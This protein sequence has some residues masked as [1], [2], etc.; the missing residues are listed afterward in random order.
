MSRPSVVVAA[1]AALALP[2]ARPASAQGDFVHGR[3]APPSSASAAV[4]EHAMHGH[5]D[6]L[7]RLHLGMTPVPTRREKARRV[8]QD[9]SGAMKFG[10]AGSIATEAACKAE[11]GKWLPSLFGW[12]VH[13][14]AWAGDP[15]RVFEH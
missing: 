2:V 14:N 5:H 11:G 13:V 1:L 15:R 9:S 7:A 4:A 6:A 10:P 12:M 3:H 8:E